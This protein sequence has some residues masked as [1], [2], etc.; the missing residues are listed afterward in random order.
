MFPAPDTNDLSQI[1]VEPGTAELTEA[2]E[3]ALDKVS[4]ALQ[5]RPA[6]KM[7]MNWRHR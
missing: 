4:Q 6:L 1:G 7:T 3:A 2:G 5:D